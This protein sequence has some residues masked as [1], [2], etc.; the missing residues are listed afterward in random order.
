MD[1]NQIAAAVLVPLIAAVLTYFGVRITSRRSMTVGR[2]ANA[3]TF[4]KDLIARVGALEDDVE[5]LKTKLEEVKGVVSHATGWIEHALRWI[6]AGSLAV[7]PKLSPKLIEH[8]N[9]WAVEEYQKYLASLEQ[10]GDGSPPTTGSD[11]GAR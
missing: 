11:T 1:W 9:P 3:V 4:S 5:D 6:M 2:E 8:M 7:P 10:N